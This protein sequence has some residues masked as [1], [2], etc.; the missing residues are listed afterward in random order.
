MTWN[1]VEKCPITNSPPRPRRSLGQNF[2]VHRATI[3]TIVRLSGLKPGDRVVELGTGLG[4]MTYELSK[5]TSGVVGIEIDKRLIKWMSERGTLPGNVELRHA[6]ILRTSFQN[7]AEKHGELLKVIGNLPYNISSQIIFKLLEERTYIDWAVLMLQK[8]LAD[9]I[10]SPSG[11]KVYG[12][13]SVVTRY[14][15]EVTRLMNI[16]PAFFRPRPKVTSTLIK[17]D[18]RS[19]IVVATD[20]AFF[21]RVV[22]QAFQQRRK[23]LIN[24]LKGLIPFSQDQILHA[25]DACGIDPG[26]RAEV[27][28]TE[29]FVSLANALPR[30][31]EKGLSS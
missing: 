24:A 28:E 18:F 10:L 3:E 25:L 30:S 26:C 29:D 21:K 27:L 22:R 16:P 13:L 23:K 12:I 17:M 2:L 7:L 15:A 20:F 19:P 5:A 14:C 4:A 1:P 11:S 8:E 6:D 9:R 31:G